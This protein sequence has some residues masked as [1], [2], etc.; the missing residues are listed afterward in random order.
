MKTKTVW[1][2][3]GATPHSG[4]V[5]YEPRMARSQQSERVSVRLHVGPARLGLVRTYSPKHVYPSKAAALRSVLRS[6]VCAVRRALRDEK[7]NASWH[8]KQVH[9]A[10]RARMKAESALAGA[11]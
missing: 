2:L 10:D 4:V 11:K 1:I 3:E 6:A 9:A 7:Q 8:R 5:V